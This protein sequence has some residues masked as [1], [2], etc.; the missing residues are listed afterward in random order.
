MLPTVYA[1]LK[2]DTSYSVSFKLAMRVE[3]EIRSPHKVDQA[4]RLP[5]LFQLHHLF[6]TS[7]KRGGLDPLCP[8][9]SLGPQNRLGLMT[10]AGV[11]PASS[12]IPLLRASPLLWPDR[13]LPISPRFSSTRDRFVVLR[14]PTRAPRRSA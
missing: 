6:Y 13:I 11:C 14:R 10:L 5:R 12:P 1:R 4:Y 3:L 2:T 8:L 7:N 9:N